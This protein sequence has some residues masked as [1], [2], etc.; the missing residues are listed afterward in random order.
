MSR[1]PSPADRVVHDLS[2]THAQVTTNLKKTTTHEQDEDADMQ[3][4][5]NASLGQ[6]MPDQENGVTGTGQQFGPATQ[7]YYEPSKWSIMPVATSRELINHPPPSKRRRI[8][9]EPAFLRGSRET[10]YLAALLTIYHS[11]PLAKEALL[12]PSLPIL[13]YGYDQNWW[14][15]SSDENRRSLTVTA[16]ANSDKNR[17]NLLAEVQCLMAFL[18]DTK[19]AYGSVDALADLYA[20]RTFQHDTPFSKFLEAWRAAAMGECPHEQLTQIF[21]STAM[22]SVGP[23]D[24]PISK[25]LVCLEPPVNRMDGQQ[26]V[27]LLDTTVWFDSTESLDDVWISHCAEIFTIHMHDPGNKDEGLQLTTSA[28]WF[29]DRYMWACRDVTREMRRQMQVIRKEI[30]HYTSLQRRFQLLWSPDRKTVSVR[31]VLEA[32]AKSTSMATQDRYSSD[33]PNDMLAQADADGVQ[34]GIQALLESIE[35]KLDALEDR[36]LELQAQMQEIG[37]QLTQ[38][39]DDPSQPPFNKYVLQGVSTKPEVTYVRRRNPDLLDL[40]NDGPDPRAEWQWWRISWETSTQSTPVHPPMIG[41]VTQAQ[42]EATKSSI[43]EWNNDEERPATYSIVK[44]S[45]QDVIEAAKTEHNSIVMVYANQNAMSFEGA[46]MS[47]ALRHFINQDNILFEREIRD[48]DRHVETGPEDAFENVPLDDRQNREMTPMS[49]SSPHRDEDGQP[50]PK[51]PKSS[52][53]EWKPLDESLPSYEDSLSHPEMQ[54]RPQNKIGMHAEKLMERY[55]NGES[56]EAEQADS[57]V[58]HVEHSKEL[59]R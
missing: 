21:T 29:P 25:D 38:A 2:D 46:P 12:L 9:G 10:G 41:P 52:E 24:T 34:P 55:G 35:N 8:D 36:K 13:A 20:M 17:L 43:N 44:V 18:D 28:V 27:D 37:R 40:E 23:E 4:A 42:A 49:V 50:S 1:P 56:I 48:A 6:E 59:P 14:N 47:Q 33:R 30:S 39:S 3:R 7:P 51:R 11:I 53:V 5:I 58:V 45:E 16:D 31:D 26:L 57:G 15:G 32:A 54:Q 19:R 22:K